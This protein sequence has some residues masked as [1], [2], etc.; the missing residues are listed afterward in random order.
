MGIGQLG[1]VRRSSRLHDSMQVS[2]TQPQRKLLEQRIFSSSLRID[3]QR[4][5]AD[6]LTS[7]LRLF[8]VSQDKT[9]IYG[10]MFDSSSP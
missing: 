1:H 5:E 8:C 7:V 6:Q 3:V 9:E 2:R 4:L 10:E